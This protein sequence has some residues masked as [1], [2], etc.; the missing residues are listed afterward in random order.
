[1]M[2]GDLYYEEMK[3]RIGPIVYQICKWVLK[4]GTMSII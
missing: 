1:M 4:N 3:I 2:H